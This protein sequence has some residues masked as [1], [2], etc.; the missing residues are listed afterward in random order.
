L[1]TTI[2]RLSALALVLGG[3]VSNAAAQQ[4]GSESSPWGLGLGVANTQKPYKGME[5]ETRALPMLRFENEYVRVGGLGLEV[6]LP[7]W[8]LGGGQRVK[9][10]IVGRLDLN[11]YEAGDA[12]IL[13]GMAERKGGFWVGGR[14]EWQNEVAELS[15]AWV[16]DAS[17]HS[18]GQRFSLGLEK[19]WRLGRQVMLVPHLTAHWMDRKYVDYYYG[20]RVEEAAAGRAAYDGKAGVNVELGLRSLYLFDKHHSALLDVAVT[21]LARRIKDSPL[22]DRSSTNRVVL[23]Y[24]YRF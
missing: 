22:V 15:A 2:W 12:P 8:E 11:G 4:P 9:F 23:G 5:R 20:V 3:V 13:A 10:G 6:K 16:A 7:S 19:N 14:A 21:S 24:M 17:G 1:A 18:K